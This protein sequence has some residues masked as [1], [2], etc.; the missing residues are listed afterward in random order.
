MSSKIHAL[1]IDILTIGEMSK[2]YL[3]K[4]S[5]DSKRLSALVKRG[6]LTRIRQGIYTDENL[7]EMPKLLISQWYEVVNHLSKRPLVA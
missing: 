6:K 5:N 2:L 3:P 7:E 1:L 4:D